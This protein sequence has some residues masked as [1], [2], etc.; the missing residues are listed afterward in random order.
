MSTSPADNRKRTTA[1]MVSTFAG[2]MLL[3]V[4]VFEIIQGIAAVAKDDVFVTGI[5]YTFNLDVSGWGW[6]HIGL[7]VIGGL[8]AIGILMGQTWGRL[9]GIAIATLSAINA[10]LF[11]PYNSIW[12]LIVIAFDVFVIW[13][14]CFQL[15]DPEEY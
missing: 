13:A 7:G 4:S 12:S 6:I 14:L 11:L 1:S 3:T 8:I 10:F 9:A 2:V 5:N 15:T